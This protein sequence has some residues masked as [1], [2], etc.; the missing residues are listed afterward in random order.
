MG[1]G[2]PI[3]HG[4]YSKAARKANEQQQ[5][6]EDVKEPKDGS[7]Y[8]Y[9]IRV[10]SRYKIGMSKDPDRRIKDLRTSCPDPLHMVHKLFSIDM[11]ALEARLHKIFENNRLHG[12]WFELDA[13][14]IE[15]IRRLT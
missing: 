4:Q 11:K 3:I 2:R 13:N 6:S 8:V 10:R 9:V 7:G 5:S 1:T 12:E 14:D 15:Y